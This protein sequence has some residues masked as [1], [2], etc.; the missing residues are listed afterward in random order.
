MR[1]L[2]TGGI[3]K[4]DFPVTERWH[5]LNCGY[6]DAF[7]P[8]EDRSGDKVFCLR[9]GIVHVKIRIPGGCAR[10]YGTLDRIDPKPYL[11]REAAQAFG[12]GERE[13][14]ETLTQAMNDR[15]PLAPSEDK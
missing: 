14:R 5:C 9:C 11:E 10:W 15:A 13:V 2:Q 4:S 6:R 3:G 7:A 1:M 8:D 12:K